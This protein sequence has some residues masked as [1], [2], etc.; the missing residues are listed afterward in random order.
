MK[1]QRSILGFFQKPSPSTP[2]GTRNAEEPVSSP[3]QRASEQRGATAVKSEKKSCE[4]SQDL[5][6][7][8]SMPSSDFVGLEHVDGASSQV[9]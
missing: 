7:L 2:S 6:D 1:N 9:F 3:A 4:S 8:P 5:Q